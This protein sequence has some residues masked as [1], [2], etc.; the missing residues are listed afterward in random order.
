[1]SSTLAGPPG[2]C[3]WTGVKHTGTPEGRV[4]LLGGLNTYIAD[5]PAGRTSTPHKKVLLFLAD[6]WGSMFVNNKLLQ[7][8]FASCGAIIVHQLLVCFGR[9]DRDGGHQ[10]SSYSDLIISLGRPFRICPRVMTGMLGFRGHA[11]P[12]SR[13]SQS[14]LMLSKRRMVCETSWHRPSE[15]LIVIGFSLLGTETTKY[16]AVGTCP[17]TSFP[18]SK[19]R[20]MH[21]E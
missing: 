4:E 19:D 13:P 1:M 12:R 6:V 14:G 15:I 11:A 21:V 2:S 10:D 3:C 7:D 9:A 18:P 17:I 16:T 5:P 8:Y 20:C